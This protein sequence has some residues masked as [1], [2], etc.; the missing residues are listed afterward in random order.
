M[1]SRTLFSTILIL[2]TSI[3]ALAD[4]AP[5]SPRPTAAGGSGGITFEVHDV[6]RSLTPFGWAIVVVGIIGIII[7]VVGIFRSRGADKAK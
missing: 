1:I 3:I 7:L 2:A 5:P 6:S 4:M